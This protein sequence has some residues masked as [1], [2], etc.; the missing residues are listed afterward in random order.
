MHD[1]SL[2]RK[3]LKFRKIFGI[4]IARDSL[5][6][7]I[8]RDNIDNKYITNFK[9]QTIVSGP[10]QKY[11]VNG[12][13]L[14]VYYKNAALTLDAVG[15]NS[16]R[17]TWGDEFNDEFSNK[18]N[19]FDSIRYYG[20][21]I[22][23]LYMDIKILLTNDRIAFYYK[24]EEIR[25]DLLPSLDNPVVLKSII[26][27]N[28]IING[29]GERALPLNLR[30]HKVKLWNHDANGSYG[31]GNDPLY[32]NIPIIVDTKKGEGYMAFYNNP[33]EGEIDICLEEDNAIKVIFTGGPADYYLL[34]GDV[35]EI[36]T[37]FSNITG[38][39]MLPPKWSFGYHQS[40]YSYE[41]QKEVEELLDQFTNL[42]FPLS[43]IHLDI[44]YMDGY[45]VFTIDK[46]RFPDMKGLSEKLK[47]HGVRLI[48]I[49]DP[50][51]K[52]DRNYSIYDEGFKNN[53]FIK[54]PEG[55]VIKGP[56]W[57]G[58]A[59]FPDF[60]DPKVKEWW[61]SKYTFFKENGIDGVWHDMNEPALFVF[62]GDNTLPHMAQQFEGPHYIAHNKYGLEMSEAGYYGLSKIENERPFILSRSGWAGIQKFAFV[63]TGDTESTWKELQQTIPTIINLGLSGIP[64]SGVDVGGFSGN[65]SEELFI[66]W[67][68]LG[69]LLPFFRNHSAK[70]TNRREPW[71]FSS[72]AQDIIR[73]FLKF[74]YKI[75]PYLFSVAYETHNN[76]LPMIRMVN[77]DSDSDLSEKTFMVGDALFAAPVLRR[78]IKETEIKLPDGKWF[79]FW[80]DTICEGKINIKIG[81]EDLPLFV[82]EGAIIPLDNKGLEF[83]IYPGETGLFTFYDDNSLQNPEYIRIDFSINKENGNYVVR[84]KSEGNLMT[85]KDKLNFIIHSDKKKT[86]TA[87]LGDGRIEFI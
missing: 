46:N 16:I 47:S 58:N 62:W 20:S 69:A 65:P 10:I 26:R 45:R 19:S 11:I 25:T 83:H 52:W 67:L 21:N 49:L 8:A 24:N 55:N 71:M 87:E 33:S 41:S 85:K 60:S 30:K 57:P 32:I 74:R 39:P 81:L 28:S 78:G 6:Y 56:V 37:N 72:K 80:D 86:I 7:T 44:D 22:E 64:Y 17:L 4:E 43:A 38:K 54:D 63:W 70:G 29:T 5:S 42:D 48:G 68:Q 73:K 51:V 77:T 23:I 79:Y 3:M 27:E 14:I 59:A 66:R 34:F 84:W 61:A 50:G 13:S 12:N 31:P 18:G 36:M 82:K 75:L 2:D 40:R 76:G 35:K 53:C 9:N 1:I 15:S